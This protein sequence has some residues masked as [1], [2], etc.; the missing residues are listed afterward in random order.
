MAEIIERL[1]MNH[2]TKR[3]P[4]VL[5]LD[6]VTMNLQKGEVLALLGENGAGKTTLMNILYG[7]YHQDEGNVLLND[8][9]IQVQGP[10]DALEYGIGMVHQHFMLVPNM[11]VLENI[12]LGM[13]QRTRFKMDLEKVR[14]RV[15][16]VADRYN[17]TVKPD[18]YIWQLSVGEQQRV[19]LVKVLTLGANLLILDEPTAA[20]TPQQT[21]ALIDLLRQMITQDTSIIFISHKLNEVKAVSDRVAVLRNGGLVFEGATKDHS[22]EDLAE[23]MA[24][25][26]ISYPK[27]SK[28]EEYGRPILQIEKV[29]A[30]GDQG[31]DSLQGVSVEVRSGEIVGIAGVSGNGQ[32]ELADVINGI[33]PVKEGRIQLDGVDI[34]NYNPQQIIDLGMGYIPED[35]MHEGTIP[36][37][38]VR[39]NLIM[40][41]YRQEPLAK[42]FF[43]RKGQIDD[44]AASLI[45]SFKV[46]TPSMA[47]S[48]AS[49]SGGNIQKVILAR[50]IT[51]KPKALVAAYPIRGLDIGASEYVHSQLIQA[52][53][54][55]MAVLL[56]SEELDELLDLCDRIAVMYE[57]KV[58]DVLPREECT[59]QELGL[60]M[61]GVSHGKE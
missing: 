57:G 23:K 44:H 34:S 51:R 10:L 5:A 9:K 46:K 53:E 2:I 31:T 29:V 27:T 25:R 47:T 56:I 39:E 32:R 59:K 26:E 49:L 7:L 43:L 38:T 33:R 15:L 18:A 30:E 6:D 24:G 36:S 1:E 12:A 45:D 13:Y 48:C 54:E 3:F 55:G 40:K 42:N 8:K 50:E 61:A 52:R 21:D 11:T 17:L 35:R 16:E 58:L 20:L 37:F 14:K 28:K 4:G 22:A 19:E 41:D 60:L